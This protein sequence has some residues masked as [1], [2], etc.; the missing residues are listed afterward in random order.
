MVHAGEAAVAYALCC[1]GLHTS[2]KLEV[3]LPMALPTAACEDN[4]AIRL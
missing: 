2:L 4:P 3:A 1:V